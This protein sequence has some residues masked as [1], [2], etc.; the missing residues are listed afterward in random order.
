[1][2]HRVLVVDD[3]DEVRVLIRRVLQTDGYEVDE[4]S[5]L[6]EARAMSPG[7]Y[8]AVLV[9]AHLGEERGIDLV[10][11][12]RSAD[13]AAAE[14]CLVITGGVLDALP[15]DIT[16]LVKPFQR[17]E[18]L[19]AVRA[20]RKPGA[21]A[22][23]GQPAIVIP[24]PAPRPAAEVSPDQ[25]IRAAALAERTQLVRR[26]P[27]SWQ[28]LDI[29]RQ[30]RARERLGLTDFL[31]DGPVQELTAV[32]LELQMLQRAAPGGQAPDLAGVLQRLDTAATSLRWL[33]GGAWP[34]ASPEANLADA[35]RQ[36]T[37]WLLA[38]DLIVEADQALAGPD[39]AETPLIADVVELLL[40]AIVPPGLLAEAHV[41]LRA[42]ESAIGID[43]TV[44]PA[45]V[46]QA[47]GDPAAARECIDALA[48]ALA[49]SA[50]SDLGELPWRV[51][52]LWRRYAE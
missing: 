2:A 21:S 48:A 15:D 6:D 3:V 42:E 10:N 16:C 43:L 47:I 45:D 31:H 52:L 9:D 39:A 13:P 50:Q 34:P 7:G 28:L 33:I 17:G 5:S 40:L 18:L 30:R 19:E 24:A 35:L 20:L 12:L 41:T 14:R 27:A 23:S 1:V 11:E 4:A 22:P 32:N 29:S 25:P 26:W 44:T 8:D 49:V 36:Q 51:R 38:T 46:D 37:A